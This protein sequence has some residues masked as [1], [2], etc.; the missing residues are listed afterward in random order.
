MPYLVQDNVTLRDAQ[1]NPYQVSGA[2]ALCRCGYS[3]T[4]PF[5]DGSHEKTSFAAVNWASTMMAP[6][7]AS[8]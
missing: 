8:R 7:L 3:Y 4:K 1:G 2:I 5:C 6:A